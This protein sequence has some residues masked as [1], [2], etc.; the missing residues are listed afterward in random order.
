MLQQSTFV[1][2]N[3]HCFGRVIKRCGY[4]RAG[5]RTIRSN[6][7]S[8]DDGRGH[9]IEVRCFLGR[10]RN[11]EQN[12]RR[13]DHQYSASVRAIWLKVAAVLPLWAAALAVLAA[14]ATRPAG[15]AILISAMVASAIAFTKIRSCLAVGV[16][17]GPMMRAD[18]PTTPLSL[19]HGLRQQI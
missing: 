6:P 19:P 2:R 4:G 15:S 3:G 16:G 18:T 14:R 12:S 17:T 11:A 8:P 7:P 9:G 10:E 13:T 5:P 1:L